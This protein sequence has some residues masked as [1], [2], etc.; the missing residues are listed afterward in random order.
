MTP[1]TV[2]AL[3]AMVA[4]CAPPPEITWQRMVAHVLHES[5]GIPTAIHDNTA[6][7]SYYPETAAAAAILARQLLA[8]GHNIDGGLGQ[9]NSPNWGPLHLS[10]ER[11]FDPQSNVCGAVIIRTQGLDIERRASN[12]YACGKPDC[13]KNP[14]YA[15]AIERMQAEL[16]RGWQPQPAT[17]RLETPPA[18]PPAQ[19][20]SAP[21]WDTWGQQECR[22]TVARGNA[23]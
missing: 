22:D 5:G 16:A 3:Q 4:V 15:D 6:N 9:L 21:S 19:T 13:P 20:C 2:T 18:T 23:Q 14:G 11:V 10:P 8:A 17:A 12:R 1:L 7:R